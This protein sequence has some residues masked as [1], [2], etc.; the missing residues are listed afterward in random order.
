MPDYSYLS[1][2]GMETEPKQLRVMKKLSAHLA[3]TPGFEGIKV[4][5][6]LAVITSKEIEDALSLLEAP[7]S[8]FGEGVGYGKTKRA[9]QWALI[10]QGFPIDDRQNPSDPAYILK[11]AVETQLAA[12]VDNDSQDGVQRRDDLYLLGGD[13]ASMDI[14]QGIVRP[15]N[16][17]SGS[18]RL[19]EFFIPLLLEIQTDKSKPHL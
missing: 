19:A 9:E 18:S 7:R 5:R 14:G 13:I 16:Q 2:P 8:L 6:G 15:A 12:I 3:R 10:L 1:Y 11:A 17:E 4:F